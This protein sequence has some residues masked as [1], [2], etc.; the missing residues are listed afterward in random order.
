[1]ETPINPAIEPIVREFK[2]ALQ[3]LY[4]DRLHDV[5]LYGSYARGDYDDESDIDLMVLLK[6]EQVNTYAEIRKIIDIET[7]FLLKYGLAISP[8]PVSYAKYKTAYGGV[9]QEARKEGVF[10]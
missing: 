2:A 8:L 9:Y 3:L 1:M 6:D 4:G 10:L 7:G 5:V